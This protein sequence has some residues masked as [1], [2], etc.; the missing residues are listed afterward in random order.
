MVS[1]ICKK[2]KLEKKLGY[3]VCRGEKR[4]GA[5]RY[6]LTKILPGRQTLGHCHIPNLPELFEVLSGKAIFLTQKNKKIYAVEAKKNEKVVILPEFS[7]R[8][9]NASDS[10]ILIIS[11]WINKRAKND[12]NAFKNIPKP[13]KVKPKKLPKE[14]ENLDFLSNPGKY[15]KFLT[16]EKLYR[17]DGEIGR[18]A[19]FRS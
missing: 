18:R 10:K 11:N 6:D 17:W 4:Q 3:D 1:L 19:S 16:V 12:Y 2:G 15:K 13:I 5:L 14:L 8:T 9:I 7:I